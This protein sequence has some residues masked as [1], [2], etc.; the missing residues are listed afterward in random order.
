MGDTTR[1]QWAGR[2]WNPVTG[3]TP[4]SPGCTNCYAQKMAGRL[5]RMGIEN[6]VDGF[7]VRTHENMLAKPLK[8]KE[9]G[10]VFVVSMGDLFH[11]QV[12]DDFIARVFDVM[13]QTPEQT[14]ILCT[15]RPL[16]FRELPNPPLPNVWGGVTVESRA[17]SVMRRVNDL[18]RA[19]F[20]KRWVSAEPLLESLGER[21]AGYIPEL[22]WVV[23]GGESGTGARPCMVRWL[24]ELRLECA[25]ARKPFFCKQ[26]GRDPR[27][28]INEDFGGPFAEHVQLISIAPPTPASVPRLESE[29]SSHVKLRDSKGGDD[30][31]WPEKM[32]VRQ[33]PDNRGV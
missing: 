3:C 21:F 24:D 22:D 18:L 15:K 19:P 7:E 29:G 17:P 25:L 28:T 6:Y 1:I 11:D 23:A 33:Y 5:Q 32:R 20:A 13:R 12:P 16:Q 27:I 10:R 9:P 31:E 30:R 14:Y 26:F 4:I 8:W 2:T